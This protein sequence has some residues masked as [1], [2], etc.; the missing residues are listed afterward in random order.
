MESSGRN[1]HSPPY[2]GNRTWPGPLEGRSYPMP[3]ANSVREPSARVVLSLV[4]SWVL[5]IVSSCG[6]KGV[7]LLVARFGK[8][9]D[10]TP[11]ESTGLRGPA[12][13]GLA[14]LT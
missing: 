11:A 8:M 9:L 6:K 10:Q 7:L 2:S 4:R 13:G 1:V 5:F 12:V 3:G 14:A